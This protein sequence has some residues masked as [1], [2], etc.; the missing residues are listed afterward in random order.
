MPAALEIRRLSKTFGGE[1]ALEDVRLTVLPGEVHGLL[2]QNGSGKSTLI[3]ILAGY[4]EPEPGA[5]LEVF[6][7]TARLPL[8]PSAFRKL[9]LAFVHQNLGLMPSLSVLENLR[10]GELATRNTPYLSWTRERRRAKEVF[11]RFGLAIDPDERIA[12]L[13]QVERALVAIVRA[14][15]D[16]RESQRR[17]QQR[18][19]LGSGRTNAVSSPRRS[20]S[21]L[22][23]GAS[24]RPKGRQ[25]A[26]RLA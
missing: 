10:I 3:K 18:W 16:I 11:A 13:P 14:F 4:H 26:I 1:K 15:E 24:D 22:R 19:Y 12:D 6:G 9:G 8:P 7:R 23:S 2:G 21:A 17:T 25:R 20:R 5:E